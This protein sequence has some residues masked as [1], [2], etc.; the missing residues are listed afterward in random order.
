ML[1][2][3]LI[4]REG[5]VVGVCADADDAPR[6]DAQPNRPGDRI[7]TLRITGEIPLLELH[8]RLKYDRTTGQLHLT[9]C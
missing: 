4:D 8:R 2:R 6:T 3:A 5:E 7:S 9:S 1:L